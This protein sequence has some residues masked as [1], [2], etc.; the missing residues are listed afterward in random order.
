[1]KSEG[2]KMNL[3][4]TR[5]NLKNFVAN[6]DSIFPERIATSI[7]LSKVPRYYQTNAVHT[8]IDYLEVGFRRLLYVSPTGTGKT[9][10]S[11]LTATSIKLREM[12]GINEKIRNNP[13]YK[14]RVL[15]IAGQQRLLRQAIEEFEECGDIEFIAHSAFQ[16]VPDE[17]IAQGWDMT[18]IDEAHHEAM[19]SIQRL[20][21]VVQEKPIFGLTAT[22]DRGD[23]LLLKFERFIFPITKEQAI[24]RKFI[25]TPSINS[26]VDTSGTNKLAIAKEVIELYYDQM[27]QTIVYFKTQKECEEFR[28]FCDA[29]GY[30]AFWLQGDANMDEILE[31]FSNGVFKLLLN[32]QKLGEGVDILNCTDVLLARQ[33]KS[34]GEKEQYV[35]RAIR[36]DSTCTVWEFINPFKDNVPTKSLFPVVHYHKLIYKQHGKW[37]EKIIEQNTDEDI[38]DTEYFKSVEN[39]S[40]A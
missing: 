8:A 21:D 15:F 4:H 14:V 5:S 27:G 34:R 23:G 3:M 7:V 39:N 1:M 38:Y 24:R 18:F 31:D 17:V 25:A 10:L 29:S 9:L 2:L 11:K 30:S 13:D 19:T 36:P 37:H 32:C 35:G 40:L 26:I 33:F 12:L 28:D 6:H 20:L 22:P 16:D